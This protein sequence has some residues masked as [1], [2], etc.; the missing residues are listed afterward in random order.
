[1]GAKISETV[2]PTPPVECLSIIGP[3]KCQ[4]SVLP[5]FFI[6]KVNSTLS[7]KVIPFKQ[8]AIAKAAIC[9][10]V[11]ELLVKLVTNQ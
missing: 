6:A 9:P 11:M 8:T 10:S 3:G 4:D 5:L 2:S 1:M 7:S